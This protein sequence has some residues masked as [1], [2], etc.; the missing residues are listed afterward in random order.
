MDVDESSCV[1]TNDR[2]GY[3]IQGTK[4]RLLRGKE[5]LCE[6]EVGT[7]PEVE[8]CLSLSVGDDLLLTP[9][10]VF[11]EPAVHNEDEIVY[12][13]AQIGCSLSAVFTDARP[14]ERIFFDDGKIGGAIRAVRQEGGEL[15]PEV[16]ITMPLTALP[17]FVPKKALTFPIRSSIFR[18]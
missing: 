7:L 12:Q 15:L 17:N 5:I 8:H 9:V 3:V 16:K 2:T 11:G 6:D 18:R 14:G 4:L 13:P 1:C 10:E